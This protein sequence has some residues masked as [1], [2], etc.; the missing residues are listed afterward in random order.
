MIIRISDNTATNV[1]ID[2][3]GMYNINNMLAYHGYE[4]TR[5]NRKMMDFDAV[6]RGVQ[7][8][9]SAAESARMMYAIL[10]GK[11]TNEA[12]CKKMIEMLLTCADVTTIPRYIPRTIPV[13]HKTGTLDYVRGDVGI[14][15]GKCYYCLAEPNMDQVDLHLESTPICKYNL[16]LPSVYQ[17]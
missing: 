17:G 9:T 13:A 1:L 11:I 10:T 3:I 4:N 15:Y 16:F 6:K 2:K 8:Y 14:I 7:N 5:L 12:S